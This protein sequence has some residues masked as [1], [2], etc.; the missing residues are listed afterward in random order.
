MASGQKLARATQIRVIRHNSGYGIAA[1]VMRRERR[2][3]TVLCFLLHNTPNDLGAESDAP[4][5]SSLVDRTKERARRNPGGPNPGVN[6]SLHPFR[7]R[8]GVSGL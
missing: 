8:N 2:N 4:N 7:D 1:K 5:P 3:L 6:S